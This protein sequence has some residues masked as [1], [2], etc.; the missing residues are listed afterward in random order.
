[1][2]TRVGPA[3]HREKARDERIDRHTHVGDARRRR[4]RPRWGGNPLP[5]VRGRRLRGLRRAIPLCDG[6]PSAHVPPSLPHSVTRTSQAERPAEHGNGRIARARAIGIARDADGRG[7]IQVAGGGTKRGQA[8][9]DSRRTSPPGAG[10]VQVQKALSA[11]ILSPATAGIGP[12]PVAQTR[13][14]FVALAAPPRF[15]TS[16][17]TS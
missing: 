1:M 10:F 11:A 4:H 2:R 9:A 14:G 16:S 3:E 17:R 8:A 6:S 5:L 12:E 7:R 13:R 15:V